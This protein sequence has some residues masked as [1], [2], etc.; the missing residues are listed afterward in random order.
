MV[1]PLSPPPF[2]LVNARLIDPESG[3][4]T[5]GGVWVE[6]GLIKALGP[7]VSPA[8]LPQDLP[9]INCGG[10]VVSPG[11]IDLRAYVG[12]P[13][14]EHRESIATATAAAAVGGV[15][16]IVAS[17]EATPPVDDPAVVDF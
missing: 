12:E 17:P 1:Q 9:R 3:I 2:A 10:D 4:E 8:N 5:R 16:T 11:L 15:T 6:N 14:G 13:G 7:D